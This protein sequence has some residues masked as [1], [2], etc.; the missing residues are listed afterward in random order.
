MG[1][2]VVFVARGRGKGA[3]RS[4]HADKRW[5]DCT[6]IGLGKSAQLANDRLVEGQRFGTRRAHRCFA[7]LSY[8]EEVV[9]LPFAHLFAIAAS[10]ERLIRSIR[11]RL[12]RLMR[13]FFGPVIVQKPFASDLLLELQ[14]FC[15]GFIHFSL[16]RGSLGDSH[17]LR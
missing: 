10:E 6:Q 8:V 9:R 12:M 1:A 11:R 7:K 15:N 5:L 3:N 16:A 17:L 13:L 2:Q 14:T 4:A